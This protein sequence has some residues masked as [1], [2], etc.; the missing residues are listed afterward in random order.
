[1]E[2]RGAGRSPCFAAGIHC[3]RSSFRLVLRVPFA[4]LNGRKRDRQNS[5]PIWTLMGQAKSGGQAMLG[6]IKP[7]GP[8]LWGRTATLTP[9]NNK[10]DIHTRGY[11][12]L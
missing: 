1:L 9:P 6:E 2:S 10:S 4:T 5:G 8:K 3:R 7:K 11:P 12:W